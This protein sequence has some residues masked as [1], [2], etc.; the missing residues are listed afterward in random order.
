MQCFGLTVPLV[1]KA[2]GTKFGKTES[3]AVWLDAKK[4]SPYSFYQFWMNTADADVYKFMRFFTFLSLEQ[5]AQIEAHD[6]TLTGRKTAQG[7]LAEE[8]TRMVH[9]QTALDSAKRIT[10][11]LFSGELS[12]LSAQELEQLV[13]DGLPAS[14]LQGL[15]SMKNLYHAAYRSRLGAGGARSERCLGA[16][17]RSGE[18]SDT[19]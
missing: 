9:G 1:T 2:D 7:I 16:Q 10:E 3:G 13:Q 5:I 14:S 6:A 11:A 4:T 12:S 17:C 18:S 8:V 19:G 15:I